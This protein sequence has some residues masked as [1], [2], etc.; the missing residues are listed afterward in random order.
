MSTALILLQH[1]FN[2]IQS[3]QRSI[4]IHS[5]PQKHIKP[6]TDA[7]LAAEAD[8]AAAY[9]MYSKQQHALL[10]IWAQSSKRLWTSE[11]FKNQKKTS[12]R[13]RSKLCRLGHIYKQTRQIQAATDRYE[14]TQTDADRHRRAQTDTD[15]E[16]LE[17]H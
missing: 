4:Q 1:Y 10:R 5:S 8:V 12:I 2:C 17:K 3:V 13:T 7:D 11:Y 9:N 6:E 14:Q 16:Q 15:K